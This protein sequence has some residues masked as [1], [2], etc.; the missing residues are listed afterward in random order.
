MWCTGVR[1]G[2]MQG[3]MF[4]DIDFEN[5]TVRINKSIDTKQA[6]QRYVINPTKTK[7]PVN[8]GV[9]TI[10]VGTIGIESVY[11]VML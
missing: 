7:T 6:G 8:T 1:I 3:I 4:E 9:F 5:K 2:E 11:F 10:L